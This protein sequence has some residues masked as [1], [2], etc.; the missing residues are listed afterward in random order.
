MFWPAPTPNFLAH[1]KVKEMDIKHKEMIPFVLG[2]LRVKFAMKLVEEKIG[3][4]NISL[5]NS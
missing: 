4:A 3:Q 5:V 1:E 2:A